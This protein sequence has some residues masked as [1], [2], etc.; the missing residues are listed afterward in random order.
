MI[1]QDYSST[2]FLKA[3]QNA[4]VARIAKLPKLHSLSHILDTW[5]MSV[6]QACSPN[7][8][9]PACEYLTILGM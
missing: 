1:E 7:A 3:V 4:L 8:I 2:A 5:E 6:R 9:K